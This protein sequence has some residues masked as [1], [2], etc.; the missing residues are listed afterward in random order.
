M[1]ARKQAELYREVGRRIAAARNAR[2]WSQTKLGTEAS[3]SRGSVANI[4]GGTQQPPLWTIWKLAV[5]LDVE[6]RSLIPTLRVLSRGRD[7]PSV[8]EL[9]PKAREI[10]DGIGPSTR[11]ALDALT[12]KVHSVDNP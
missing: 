3:L 4:E 1:T 6:P 12:S 2:N 7:L 10:V 5:A 9:P 8:H 11:R